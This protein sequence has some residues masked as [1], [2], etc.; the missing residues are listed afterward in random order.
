M[1]VFLKSQA[2]KNR[3]IAHLIFNHE[4][5]QIDQIDKSLNYYS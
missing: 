5:H 3:S 1:H 4:I 2:W